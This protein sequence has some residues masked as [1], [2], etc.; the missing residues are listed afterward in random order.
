MAAPALAGDTAEVGELTA[1]TA[2]VVKVAARAGIAVVATEVTC[3]SR[4]TAFAEPMLPRLPLTIAA[5]VV[6]ACCTTVAI[7]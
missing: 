4:L 1:N 2:W 3:A 7:A 5:T 6:T